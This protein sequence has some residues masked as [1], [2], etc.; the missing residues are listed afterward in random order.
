MFISELLFE[1]DMNLALGLI[2]A[3]AEESEEVNQNLEALFFRKSHLILS[4]GKDQED[5]AL[6]RAGYYILKPD[7]SVDK[8]TDAS[9]LFRHIT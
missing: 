6:A 2:A 9:V 4:T 7:F 5:K 1:A 8:T 3:D